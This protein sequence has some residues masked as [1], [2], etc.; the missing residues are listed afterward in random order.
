MPC[1][2]MKTLLCLD[3]P[4][5]T[6]VHQVQTQ[7]LI[8]NG[9]RLP[10]TQAFGCFPEGSHGP[11]PTSLE[12][13]TQPLQMSLFQRRNGDKL[14]QEAGW[15]SHGFPSRL[16][17]HFKSI[18]STPQRDASTWVW[19][20]SQQQ[21]SKFPAVALDDCALCPNPMSP[22]SF[23]LFFLLLLSGAGGFFF[24][25]PAGEFPNICGS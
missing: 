22:A 11:A 25:K 2:Y 3:F 20:S 12:M 17:D 18:A 9:P 4:H 10:K 19:S 1:T 24:M 8:L 16:L 5:H 21:E 15:R 13:G 14:L 6:K 23:L 7:I